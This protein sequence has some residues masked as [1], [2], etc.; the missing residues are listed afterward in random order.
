MSIAQSA[1][2]N[3]EHIASPLYLGVDGGGSKTLA[4]IVDAQGQERGRGLAGGANYEAVGLEVAVQNI[5]AAVQLAL[6]AAHGHLPVRKAWLGLAGLD[7]PADYEAL[8]PRLCSLAEFVHLTNDA[9]LALSAVDNAVGV[10]LIAGTGS[11]ALGR[12]AHGTTLRT[13]GW[14]YLIGDEGSGYDIGR[15]GLQAAVRAADGR[16]QQTLLLASIMQHWNLQRADDIIGR[17]YADHDKAGIAQLSTCVFQAARQG[18]VVAHAIVQGAADELALAVKT[19]SEKL[20]FRQQP[21]PLALGGGLLLHEH[22]FRSL[23]LDM[24]RQ[25][26]VLGQ[27]AH[28]EEP[29]LDAARTVITL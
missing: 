29:A 24:I 13:G 4:V 17:V 20:D 12:N 15:Q 25:H 27:I 10:A 1:Q 8:F 28:S 14:G 5:S 23:V 11:I 6:S 9:D 7:R 21:L 22:D 3:Q 26:Q 19:V 16:G 2:Y 18:D